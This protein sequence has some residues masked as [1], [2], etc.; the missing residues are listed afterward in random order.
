MIQ[1]RDAREVLNILRDIKVYIFIQSKNDALGELILT[2]IDR[3]LEDNDNITVG[4]NNET[5]KDEQTGQ[6]NSNK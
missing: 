3:I 4:D 5:T 6:E 1:F 2:R